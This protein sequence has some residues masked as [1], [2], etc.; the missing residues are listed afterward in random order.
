MILTESI[1]E[2]LKQFWSGL[3]NEFDKPYWQYII[4]CIQSDINNGKKILPNNDDILNALIYTPLKDVKVCI[5]GQDPYPNAQDAHGLSFSS[6]SILT[7]KSLQNI[8][9]E[10]KH[11]YHGVVFNTN[12]L[13]SWTKQGVLLL[14]KT[15]TLIEGIPL[16]HANIGWNNFTKRIIKLIN[17]ED[18][19]IIWL[20]MGDQAIGNQQF[21]TNS[22]HIVIK[23]SHPSP[24]G[25][26]KKSKLSDCAFNGSK[27]FEKINILL[28][29][30]LITEINWET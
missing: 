13:T 28:K 29:Q 5:L 7:P 21:I 2:N 23:T 11:S 22:K 20:L 6:N 15:L 4:N 17:N 12:N 18:R 10:I 25:A 9:G 19:P 27:V 30:N 24:L 14:N 1:K 16:S 8:F 3:L 26:W